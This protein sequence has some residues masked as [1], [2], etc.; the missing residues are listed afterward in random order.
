M[1]HTPVIANPQQASGWSNLSTAGSCNLFPVGI[2]NW[3]GLG[4]TSRAGF[5]LG[6]EMT[7]ESRQSDAPNQDG[8]PSFFP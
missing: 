7:A 3:A 5:R 8:G 4:F 6:V 2:G 1:Y